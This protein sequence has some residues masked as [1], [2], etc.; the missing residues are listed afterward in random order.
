MSLDLYIFFH[1][2]GHGRNP[3]QVLILTLTLSWT[4][5]LTLTLTQDKTDNVRDKLRALSF[6]SHGCL[7][8]VKWK[9]WQLLDSNWLPCWMD[10]IYPIRNNLAKIFAHEN[11]TK[12]GKEPR[13]LG[14]THSLPQNHH[15]SIHCNTRVWSLG[16]SFLFPP[17]PRK[18]V[19][20]W[21][22]FLFVT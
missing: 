14:G 1:R 2:K 3:F 21:N 16:L 5:K 15:P 10:Y 7:V 12:N 20:R 8:W 4:L 22:N 11:S 13:L 9:S 17:P 6:S 19:I 18:V